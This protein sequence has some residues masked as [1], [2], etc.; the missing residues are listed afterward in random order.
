MIMLAPSSRALVVMQP[1]FTR[2]GGASIVMKSSGP[3]VCPGSHKTNRCRL[4]YERT[5]E[6]RVRPP[7]VITKMRSRECREMLTRLGYGRLACA[8]NNRPYI[9]PFYFAYDADRLCCF[10]TVGRKIEWMRLN[11][12]VCVQVEEI[13]GHDEWTSVVV[14]GQYI[15][16]PNGREFAESRGYIRSLLKKRALWWQS[17]YTASQVRRKPKPPIS[18]FFNIRIEELTGLRATPDTRENANRRVKP[19]SE[20]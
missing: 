8:S 18:V 2:V 19:I 13:R 6:P 3:T 5:G 10:S 11:P 15:E 20:S 7:M 16:I 14:M 9:V 4:T 1:Q 12:L 17:G